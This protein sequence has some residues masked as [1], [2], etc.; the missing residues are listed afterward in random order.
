MHQ[1]SLID[2][3]IYKIPTVNTDDLFNATFFH[4]RRNIYDSHGQN[5]LISLAGS[6]KLISKGEASRNF[7]KEFIGVLNAGGGII[8]FDTVRNF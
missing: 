8:L 6:S 7:L 5:C 1:K 3:S 2:Q 4:S